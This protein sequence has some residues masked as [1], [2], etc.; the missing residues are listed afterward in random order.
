MIEYVVIEAATSGRLADYVNSHIKAG[1]RPQGGVA[2]TAN[3][4]NEFPTFYQAM[5]RTHLT[6]NKEPVNLDSVDPRT[7]TRS[8]YR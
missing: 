6:K 7:Q 4:R 2:V 1:W 3:E 5:M 8:E